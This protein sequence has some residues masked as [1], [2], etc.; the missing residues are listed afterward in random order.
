MNKKFSDD[1]IAAMTPADRLDNSVKPYSFGTGFGRQFVGI[2]TTMSAGDKVTI[3]GLL[4]T[5]TFVAAGV[6][7]G[8]FV[9]RA[10]RGRQ[11]KEQEV[12]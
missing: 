11:E 3:G 5:A 10:I 4:A 12:A 7:G 9:G 1:E 6:V 2:P 8:H